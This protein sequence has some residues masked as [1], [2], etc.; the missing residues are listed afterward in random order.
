MHKNMYIKQKKIYTLRGGGEAE[1]AHINQTKNNWFAQK[2]NIFDCWREQT[3][4]IY[5]SLVA[6]ANF[7]YKCT[8]VS[9]EVGKHSKKRHTWSRFIDSSMV[10]IQAV[11]N[12]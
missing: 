1:H 6:I 3:I 5:D 12:L 9:F 2:L 10:G 7:Q 8:S 11:F 4:K